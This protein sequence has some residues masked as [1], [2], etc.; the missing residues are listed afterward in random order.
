M[1]LSSPEAA[2][3]WYDTLIFNYTAT[4]AAVFML[5]D[6]LIS[7]GREVEMFWGKPISAASILFFSNKVL[8]IA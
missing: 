8:T 4:A 1:S 2:A 6:Y 5:Y 3:A 7:T